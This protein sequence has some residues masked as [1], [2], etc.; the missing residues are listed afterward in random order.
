MG[1]KI[2]NKKGGIFKKGE[3]TLE[4]VIAAVREN[5]DFYKAGAIVSF[6]GVVRGVTKE[7]E[8]VLGLEL[9]AYEEKAEEVLLEIVREIESREDIVD[10]RIF[11]AVGDFSVGEDLVYVVLAGGHREDLFPALKE[12]VES[13]KKRAYIWK[14]EKTISCERWLEE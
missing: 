2:G 9:E 14:K 6:V 3:V 1:S 8:E 5:S 12:A 4:E 11:H 7:G 13:Y 10:A